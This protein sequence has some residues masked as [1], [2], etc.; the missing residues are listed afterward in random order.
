MVAAFPPKAPGHLP[1]PAPCDPYDNAE[2]MRLLIEK[3]RTDYDGPVFV[4]Y[5]GE[6]YP[7]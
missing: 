2:M 3:K 7:W 6:E 5:E 1:S 4:T